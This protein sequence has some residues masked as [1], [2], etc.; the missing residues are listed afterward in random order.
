MSTKDIHG[1]IIDTRGIIERIEELE[2]ER[3]AL[4]DR[5]DAADAAH[6]NGTH[7]DIVDAHAAL[8]E[9]DDSDEGQELATLLSLMEDLAGNGGDEQ[10]RGDWYPVTLIHEDHF[11]QAMQE[12]CEDSGD[13]PKDAPSYLVIDW[14]ATAENLRADYSSVEFEGETYWYR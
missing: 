8:K 2:E 1:D 3:A 11:V 12:L 14:S 10:W 9:W 6:A 7:Q 4:S 5:I 13:L